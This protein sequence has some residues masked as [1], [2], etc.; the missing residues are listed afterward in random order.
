MI[1]HFNVKGESRKAMVKAIEKELGVKARYLGVP[2][3]S[4]EI[5]SYTIGKNGELEFA[6]DLA[7]DET[8]KV[9]DACVMTT[10]V[11]PEEWENNTEEPE[12]EPQGETVGLTVAIPIDKVKVGNLTALIDS[13]AGLI[14]KA[15]GID[16]LGISIEE[17]KVSF[18]W[19]S[20]GIDADTLQTYTRF[21]A[22]NERI[23]L[24]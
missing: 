5:G 10:G 21:I 4:Y 2:S 24:Q 8:S 9:V 14:K 17:D 16:D 6:D 7:M 20:E 11:S 15:L 12:T 22:V 23:T 3:C 18:P 1:L 19:F 13:K